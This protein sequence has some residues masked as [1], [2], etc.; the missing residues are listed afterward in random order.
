[1]N[2]TYEPVEPLREDIDRLPGP[3][4]VEFGS[5]SCGFCSAA[6][7]LLASAL[8]GHPGVRHIKISDGSGRRLGRTFS[9]KLWPTFVFLDGG[10]EVAR[11]VRPEDAAAIRKGLA[12]IDAK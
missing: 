1:M 11:V 12:Q 3:T 9:V 7:P 6:Q 8:K 4:L 10:R 5:P 2:D